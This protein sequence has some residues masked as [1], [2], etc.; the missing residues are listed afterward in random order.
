MR[1]G[2]RRAVLTA[3]GR[4]EHHARALAARQRRGKPQLAVPTPVDGS[5]SAREWRIRRNGDRAA[6]PE[7]RKRRGQCADEGSC[8]GVDAL[9]CPFE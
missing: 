6:D 7:T 9:T 3:S 2:L 4:A 1:K 5:T 8:G